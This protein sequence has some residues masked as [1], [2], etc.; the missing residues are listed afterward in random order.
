MPAHSS[1]HRRTHSSQLPPSTHS[2]QYPPH[3]WRCAP[4]SYPLLHIPFFP[5]LLPIPL[6]AAASLLSRVV[7]LV[8]SMLWVIASEILSVSGFDTP[9]SIATHREQISSVV[10][11]ARDAFLWALVPLVACSL[12]LFTCKLLMRQSACRR[13]QALAK[14]LYVYASYTHNR[15]KYAPIHIRRIAK[16]GS[17]LSKQ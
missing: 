7:G 10:H 5:F 11:S 13:R 9:V 12:T 15:L 6:S 2:S 1:P 16:V 4:S 8:F 14:L 17:Q 3:T